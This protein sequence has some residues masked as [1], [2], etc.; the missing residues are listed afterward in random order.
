MNMNAVLVPVLFILLASPGLTALEPGPR[1]EAAQVHDP[2]TLVKCKAEYWLFATGRGILSRRSKDLVTW[3]SGPP[4]FTKAPLWTTNVVRDHR[5]FFWAPDVTQVGG[6]YLLYYSVSTWGKNTSAIGLATNPTLDPADPDHHWTDQ[7]IV[8]QSGLK[9]DFNAIDPG[10][11]QD[12]NGKLWLVFGSFWTGIKLVQLNPATGKSL[13]PDSPIYSLARHD[14]IEAP[15]LHRQGGYYYLFVNWG[16]CCRG[17]NSTYNIRVGRSAQITGPYRDRSGADMRGG[18]GSAF[19]ET[20]GPF[21]GPGHAG[22]LSE[23]GTNW[24]S[25]H[26]YDGTRSGVA[27]LSLRPLQWDADG[28]PVLL[29]AK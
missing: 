21:I 28:W 27:T 9:D 15:C 10:V 6:R 16:L 13:E 20:T 12:A 3:R 18:G 25:C 29:Q 17:T 14:P 11:I 22:V 5:G 8:V 1:Q 23:G 4:V 7:G 2:S 24:L 26:F 19:L